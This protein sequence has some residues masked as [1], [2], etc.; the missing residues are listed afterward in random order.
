[1]AAAAA[2]LG[3][4]LGAG[5]DPAAGAVGGSDGEGSSGE[6]ATGDG[7][8]CSSSPVK[9]NEEEEAEGAARPPQ[10][11]AAATRGG[12]VA[13]PTATASPSALPQ[14]PPWN[15]RLEEVRTANGQ[16]RFYRVVLTSSFTV[17]V[18]SHTGGMH[19]MQT[20][21]CAVA[22][23]LV[24]PPSGDHYRFLLSHFSVCRALL[25]RTLAFGLSTTQRFFAQ[26][27]AAQARSAE[28]GVGRV[29]PQVQ[30]RMLRSITGLLEKDDAAVGTYEALKA[31]L[32]ASLALR[33]PLPH[34]F[35]LSGR[36]R[37]PAAVPFC[38][39]S[40]RAPSSPAASAA[41]C[42]AEPTAP[43]V[44]VS[45][46]L[47][48]A[49]ADLSAYS[50]DFL[51]ACVAGLIAIGEGRGAVGGEDPWAEC[52]S[53]LGKRVA[54]T[55]ASV[56]ATH[57]SQDEQSAD[58][59]AATA[60][61]MAMAV[62]GASLR[63][64][65]PVL[66]A[67]PTPAASRRGSA[68]AASEA[69]AAAATPRRPVRGACS[70]S[71]GGSSAYTATP[72]PA[73]AGVGYSG[74][75]VL[76]TPAP[77]SAAKPPT[78]EGFVLSSA[79]EARVVVFCVDPV[80]AQRLLVVASFFLGC[81]GADSGEHP[82]HH[83]SGEGEGGG[84]TEEVWRSEARM[85]YQHCFA[86]KVG[87][88]GARSATVPV[89]WIP[90]E[91]S[92]QQQERLLGCVYSPE[93]A[94]LILAPRTLLC[95]E[96][97]LR[98]TLETLTVSVEQPPPGA[99]AD[100][101]ARLHRQSQATRLFR[102]RLQSQRSVPPDPMVGTLLKEA[103]ALEQGS[104]GAVP[105]VGVLR[106]MVAWLACQDRARALQQA[107][108]GYDVL[109]DDPNAVGRGSDGGAA[110]GKGDHRSGSNGRD[111]VLS[112]VRRPS[113]LSF[114]PAATPITGGGGAF[115]SSSPVG[116]WR[117]PAAPPLPHGSSGRGVSV[118]SHD[119]G[120]TARSP[121][122]QGVL[123]P[124]SCRS[125]GH[126][127]S[128]A[129]RAPEES[130]PHGGLLRFLGT[131]GVLLPAELWLTTGGEGGRSS[132]LP[133]TTHRGGTAATATA[134]AAATADRATTGHRDL[135]SSRASSITRFFSGLLG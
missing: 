75:D 130:S 4:A 92:E 2:A 112:C 35:W 89:Q 67:A 107:L 129:P 69:A 95:R 105:C 134:T 19:S 10:S 36:H 119:H 72:Q 76:A 18:S 118:G 58:A 135:S 47:C 115:P 110:Q 103:V 83:R 90:E 13:P 70:P 100:A 86:A 132:P 3:A 12:V 61:A 42:A 116:V 122:V 21:P 26:L 62:A 63:R 59:T 1:M 125:D 29:T 45:S 114:S 88:D 131:R 93:N 41:A 11:L 68:P 46:L 101:A 106:D 94:I 108:Y 79:R 8:G 109:A 16:L 64:R 56:S 102:C 5:V 123:L 120:V 78:R 127:E 28:G 133:A 77:P 33:Q 24:C 66:A 128:S 53:L 113:L 44:E 71:G 96:L 84:A 51:S 23:V 52:W 30:Q 20:R 97:L 74:S 14:G 121:T 85:S 57:S 104:H 82:Y 65:P 81:T 34:L 6:G 50:E 99:D 31:E 43:L 98:K 7:R 39:A 55:N 111:T 91:F 17:M 124:G 73:S 117:P 80:L 22:L 49:L 15:L 32:S 54:A 40:R 38:L 87:V 27:F 9:D 37:P 48:T 60:A 126:A 25:H